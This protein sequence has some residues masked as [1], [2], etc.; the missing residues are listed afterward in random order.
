MYVHLSVLAKKIFNLQNINLFIW[1]PFSSAT[2]TFF[3]TVCLDEPS[4]STFLK[5][6]KDIIVSGYYINTEQ[7]R[8]WTLVSY[9]GWIVEPD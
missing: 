2:Y 9:L 4:F 8:H 5:F 1:G 6:I 3:F 7:M